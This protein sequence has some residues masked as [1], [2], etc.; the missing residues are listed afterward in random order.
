MTPLTSL[1]LWHHVA[2][3][4][5]TI[6]TFTDMSAKVW[7]QQLC[8]AWRRSRKRYISGVR[9]RPH[10]ARCIRWSIRTPILLLIL[11]EYVHQTLRVKILLAALSQVVKNHQFATSPQILGW[12]SSVPIC[13]W[14][15]F[16]C[17]KADLEESHR[18]RIQHYR[19]PPTCD[20]KCRNHFHVTS[21]TIVKKFV[22][23]YF[24][25]YH[26]N[27]HQKY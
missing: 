26:V 17:R 19:G 14:E 23:F 2:I 8:S 10:P 6:F 20:S 16:V 9:Q 24:V 1:P 22:M 15:V 13:F 4:H 11:W 21:H 5:T 7:L 27:V 25:I 3:A 18:N 12:K